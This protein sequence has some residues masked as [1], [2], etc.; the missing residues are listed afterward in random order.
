MSRYHSPLG[1]GGRERKRARDIA[2]YAAMMG[3]RHRGQ[4]IYTEGG[5]RWSGIDDRRLGYKGEFPRAADC[6]AFVTWC[7]WN[8]CEHFHIKHDIVN[9]ANWREGYTGTMVEHGQRIGFHQLL[10]GDAVLYAGS[11]SVPQHTAIYVGHGRVVSHGHQGGPLLL[12]VE[13]GLPLNQA[14]RYIR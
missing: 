4:M 8:A 10:P 2:V 1:L 12:P 5:A 6:S 9:G 11:S 14:R 7:I 13:L 3:Y